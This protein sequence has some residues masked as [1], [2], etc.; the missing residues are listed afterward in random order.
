MQA[1]QS[2]LSFAEYVVLVA[3]LISI[4]AMGTDLMLP[5]LDVIGR[6]LAVA[7]ANDVQFIVTSFF[8]GMAAG[9][10]FVGPLSDSLGRKPVIYMGYGVFI[11][12]CL[13]SMFAENWTLM[14][15]GRV[16]Q[17]FGA[18]APRIVTVALVRDEHEG[19][20]MARILSVV[21]AVFILVPMIAPAMGQLL[22]YLGGW[23]A[24][25]SGLAL[26]AVVV[27]LW[28]GVRQ[29]ETLPPSGR[30]PFQVKAIWQGLREI[31]RSRI[32]VGYTAAS[33]LMYGLLVG[34]LGSAQQIFH[35]TFG[36][37]D[38]FVVYFAIAAGSLGAASLL[39]AKLVV[40][41]GMR[42][43]TWIALVG[44]TALSFSF[45]AVLLFFDGMPPLPLF[46]VWQLAAFF[47]IGIVFGNLNALS[48]EPLGHMAGLGAAF[49]GSL[50]TFMSLPIAWVI[51]NLFDGTVFPLVGGFAVLG[52]ASVCVVVWT[53]HESEAPAVHEDTT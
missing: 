52:L 2:D 35:D 27:S 6:D 48:L 13:L 33:G 12:G 47:C 21:M 42:K 34:Y 23:R 19:R 45:W 16:L 30:R 44:L 32:A 10:L 8:L 53:E 4:G 28:F 24:T 22:V 5:A 41:L 40:G 17:G 50:A 18:A 29:R 51:G 9:Q 49:V 20:V 1:R 39:N 11:G 14:L 25:F 46:V 31:T 38:L 37:G 3:L 26:L 43:L 15:V 36:V 7:N